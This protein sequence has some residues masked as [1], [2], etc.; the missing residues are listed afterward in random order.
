MLRRA[1]ELDNFLTHNQQPTRMI[2]PRNPPLTALTTNNY[3]SNPY[4]DHAKFER[5]A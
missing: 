2:S 4:A 3:F 5:N 1:N